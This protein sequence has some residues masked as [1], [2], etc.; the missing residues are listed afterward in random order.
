MIEKHK[1]GNEKQKMKTA[2]RSLADDLEPAPLTQNS[3]LLP[4]ENCDATR[5]VAR[6]KI[7]L[8]TVMIIEL[9]LPED[10]IWF[11]QR[12]ANAR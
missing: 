9:V 11:G 1:N 2:I 5:H 4:I 12:A 6:S 10:N 8:M 7:T 3:V